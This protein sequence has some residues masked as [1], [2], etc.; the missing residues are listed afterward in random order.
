[1]PPNIAVLTANNNYCANSRQGDPKA[2]PI[3]WKQV[4]RK[5]RITLLSSK[6]EWITPLSVYS[7][8]VKTSE[9]PA[10][11]ASCNKK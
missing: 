6:I 11:L 10:K 1:M 3:Q 9:A 5:F 4:K 8:A 2:I 7:S